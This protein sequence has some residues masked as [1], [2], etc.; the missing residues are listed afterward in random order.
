MPALS[1][2]RLVTYVVAALI[3]VLGMA[4][5]VGLPASAA[6][7]SQGQVSQA[8]ST[9]DPVLQNERFQ[10][11]QGRTLPPFGARNVLAPDES[12]KRQPLQGAEAAR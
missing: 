12:L 3:A 9:Q 8:Q 2:Q 4:A 10:A 6:T 5:T 11:P 1:D 7:V